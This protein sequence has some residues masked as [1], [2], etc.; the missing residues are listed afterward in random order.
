MTTSQDGTARLWDVGTGR[1]IMV[2]R[3]H[4]AAVRMAVY[5]PDG[6][7]VVTASMDKTARIWD[8]ES[9]RQIAVLA[10]HRSW[11]WSAVFSPDGRRVV[12]ASQDRTARIWDAVSGRP[13]AVIENNMDMTAPVAESNPVDDHEVAVYG[14]ISPSILEILA[15]MQNF[16]DDSD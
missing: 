1:T 7:R 14:K 15:A 6:R 13:V 12:T 5:S 11:V 3:G 8:A 16:P 2:L 10:G 4:S 9:G